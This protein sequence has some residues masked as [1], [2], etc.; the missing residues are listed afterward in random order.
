MSYKIL[1]PKTSSEKF[2]SGGIYNATEI[3]APNW[4]LDWEKEID[5]LTNK[6]LNKSIESN[7]RRIQTTI[8]HNRETRQIQNHKPV[9]LLFTVCL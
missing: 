7:T 2:L 9:I 8:R 4:Y 6:A 5:D 1:P 3:S